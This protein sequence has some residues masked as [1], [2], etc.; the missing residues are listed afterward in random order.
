MF[1]P[2]E[3]DNNSTVVSGT[4]NF[5]T[6]EE[7]ERII[8]YINKDP[9]KKVEGGV[10]GKHSIRKEYRKNL[11]RW[12]DSDDIK[13]LEWLIQRI[14]G[15]VM[16]VNTQIYQFNLTGLSESIQFTEYSDLKDKYDYH[17]DSTLGAYTRKLSV[18]IQLSDENSYK[19]CNVEIKLQEKNNIVNRKQGSITI[20]PSYLL[21]RVT[22]LLEGTRYSLVT[23]IGGPKFK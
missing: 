7:C 17:V 9:S 5:L 21:H 6:K 8:N 18:I 4:D 13:D 2:F 10:T 23:W 1:L 14:G 20:F 15:A 3:M 22:P 11:V 12:I 19:G 16:D